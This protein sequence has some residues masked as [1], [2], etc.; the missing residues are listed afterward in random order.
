MASIDRSFP[1]RRPVADVRRLLLDESFL[2][3]FVDSMEPID[4]SVR[5]DRPA[6]TA[7]CEWDNALEGQV[8]GAVLKLTG[9]RVR[10]SLTMNL[11]GQALTMTADGKLRGMMQA[12][13]RIVDGEVDGSLLHVD[14]RVRFSGMLGS[15][16]ESTARD[17][18]IVP[19]LEEDLV[20]QLEQWP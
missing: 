9:K 11:A 4:K 7:I 15:L 18:V 12:A 13:F 17:E 20:S 1:V 3:A 14:G 19:V 16:L 10:I 2:H 6:E 8:P 5:V